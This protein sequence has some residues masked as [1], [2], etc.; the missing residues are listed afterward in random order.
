MAFA[1][2]VTVG[3]GIDTID[4]GDDDE[5]CAVATENM[6]EAA[7]ALMILAEIMMC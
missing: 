7:M 4:D 3:V 6:A 1:G 2:S 5:P